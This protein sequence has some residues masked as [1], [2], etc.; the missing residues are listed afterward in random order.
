MIRQ[1]RKLKDMYDVLYDK[2]WAKQQDPDSV[3]YEMQ[4]E[5]KIKNNMRYDITI[6]PARLLGKEFVKTKGH[7]H[8]EQEEYQVLEGEAIFLLQKDNKVKAIKAKKS[9]KIIIPSNWGHVTINPSRTKTLKLANWIK[10]DSQGDY[11]EFAK[12]QGACYFYTISGWVKNPNYAEV[13]E[14]A[15]DKN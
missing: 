15:L 13:A 9:D 7:S 3:L 1:L 11:S 5:T 10:K 2:K 8:P 12:K 14:L 4:R 6:I